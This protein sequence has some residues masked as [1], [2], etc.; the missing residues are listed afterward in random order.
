[1]SHY[2]VADQAGGPPPLVDAAQ[3]VVVLLHEVALLRDLRVDPLQLGQLLRHAARAEGVQLLPELGHEV[4][5]HLVVGSHDRLQQLPG[6]STY[7]I[8]LD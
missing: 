8:T 2:Q 5:V 3:V 7:F 6:L 4:V 1:M